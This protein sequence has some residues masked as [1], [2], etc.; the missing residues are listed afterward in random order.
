MNWVR[1]DS[2]RVVS[3]CDVTD[4]I[5]KLRKTC[6]KKIIAFIEIITVR[7]FDLKQ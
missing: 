6:N 7:W 1:E 5:C 4:G 2:I 3:I